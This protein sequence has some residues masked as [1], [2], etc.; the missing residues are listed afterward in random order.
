MFFQVA[1]PCLSIYVGDKFGLHIAV[2]SH[3]LLVYLNI[4][5]IRIMMIGISLICIVVYTTV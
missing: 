4:V 3:F 5:T 1:G 2:V